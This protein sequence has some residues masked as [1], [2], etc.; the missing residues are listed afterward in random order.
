MPKKIFIGG[1][2]LQTTNPTIQS[3]FAPFGTIVAYGIN[4]DPA[5]GQSLGTAN[6]EYTTDQAGTA[7]I[8]A[9]N[10]TVLDGNTIAVRERR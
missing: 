6:V 7:A 9:K 4:V 3:N 1:L 10:G 5:T 8:A 2:S